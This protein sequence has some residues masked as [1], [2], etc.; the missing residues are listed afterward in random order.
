MSKP[1]LQYPLHPEFEELLNSCGSMTRQ[2][3]ELGQK[4]TVTLLQ[5]NVTDNQRWRI[6]T[7]NLNACPVIV[8][9]SHCDINAGFFENLLKNAAITPIGKFLFAKDS[10]VTRADNMSILSVNA[11]Q[12]NISTLRSYL[13]THGYQPD[14]LFWQR[15]SQFN[16]RDQSLFLTE[17]ILPEVELFY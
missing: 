8:A 6:I 13:N 2:L 7:L 16:Y 12:I 9:A 4:L 11:A 17:I 15:Q 5:E 3:E 1:L 10:P 14:Q